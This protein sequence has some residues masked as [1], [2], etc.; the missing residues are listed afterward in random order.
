LPRCLPQVPNIRSKVWENIQVSHG[1]A[2]E[3]LSYNGVLET[4]GIIN[5]KN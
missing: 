3:V 2:K 5:L 4:K 1:K